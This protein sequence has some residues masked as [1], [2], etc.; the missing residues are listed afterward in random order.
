MGG[1]DG[2]GVWESANDHMPI[3]LICQLE[4]SNSLGQWQCTSGSYACA[5]L[6]TTCRGRRRE[7]LS[8]PRTQ[9][10]RATRDFHFFV[11][12]QRQVRG[13][14]PPDEDMQPGSLLLDVSA[15]FGIAYVL[16]CGQLRYRRPCQNAR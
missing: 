2:A 11:R 1:S 6:G 14:C 15:S 4:V 9:R 10:E 13:P 7:G 8:M 16:P 3:A 5:G 12:K